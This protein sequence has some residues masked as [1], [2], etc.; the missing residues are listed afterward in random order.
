MWNFLK[1]QVAK[2]ESAG[3]SI[4][5]FHYSSHEKTWWRNFARNHEGKAGVPTLEEVD[6]FTADYFVD[7]LDYS[8]QVALGATGYG[9][10][11]LAP[12][13]GFNW[14]VQD[15]GG[16]LSLLKF[17]DAVDPNRSDAEQQESIDWLY[18]YNLDDVRATF[19]VRDYLRNLTF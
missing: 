10:K 15:P 18:S 5:I 7:L 14:Q 16:A 11:K 1:E 17:K 6:E 19:A 13:A 3:K 9:I 8:K 12:K 4:G 2:A